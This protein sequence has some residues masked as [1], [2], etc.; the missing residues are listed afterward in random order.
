[1]SQIHRIDYDPVEDASEL[2]VEELREELYEYLKARKEAGIAFVSTRNIRE[3][4]GVKTGQRVGRHM[5]TLR[6]QGVVERWSPGSPVTYKI[7]ING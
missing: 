5:K 2:S 4:V 3:D 7:T 1:M 6:E